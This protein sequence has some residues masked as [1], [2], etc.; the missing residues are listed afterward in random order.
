MLDITKLWDTV[1]SFVTV[2][3][4]SQGDFLAK[5]LGVILIA[6]A[7]SYTVTVVFLPFKLA[8]A[9]DIY[10]TKNKIKVIKK[11]LEEIDFTK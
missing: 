8:K 5:V 10:I 3:N 6:F 7:I 1:C 11:P 9:L 4:E 2:L